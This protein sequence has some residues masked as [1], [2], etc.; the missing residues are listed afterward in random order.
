MGRPRIRQSPQPARAPS[1]GSLGSRL[2]RP[3]KGRAA[4]RP[5]GRAPGLGQQLIGTRFARTVATGRKAWLFV[6]SDNH[7]ESAGH[8][9]SLIAFCKLHRP[10]PETYLRDLFRVLTYWPK[11]RY[12]ELA[13]KYWTR[14]RALLDP[15]ELAREL[16]PLTLQPPL[17]APAEQQLAANAPQ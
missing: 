14:T 9:F 10:D 15:G 12:L 13:P 2:R 7:A 16:G 8:I 5:R 4:A 6:G 3:P 1:L 17:S 11:D